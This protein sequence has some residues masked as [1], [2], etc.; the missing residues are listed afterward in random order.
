MRGEDRVE[1]VSQRL[2][3]IKIDA[4]RRI[5]FLNEAIV[6][7]SNIET[8][9]TF[10]FVCFCCEVAEFSRKFVFVNVRDAMRV[11][12]RL[13]C[14]SDERLRSSPKGVGQS[15]FIYL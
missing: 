9:V 7:S 5:S 6:R 1:C 8:I 3:M 10:F 15:V 12:R 14:A 2:E 11:V 13:C 4:G